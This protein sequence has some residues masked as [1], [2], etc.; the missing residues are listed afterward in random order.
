MKLIRRD[1][2]RLA[3]VNVGSLGLLGKPGRIY[4]LAQASQ[5]TGSRA[6]G[7]LFF[8][9]KQ[10]GLLEAVCNQIIPPDDYPGAKDAG[11]VNFIDRALGNWAPQHRWDYVAGLEAI[12]ESSQLM[13]G[14]SFVD[15]NWDQQTKV[16]EEIEKGSA[17]GK[18]W[19]TFHIGRGVAGVYRGDGDSEDSSQREFFALVVRHTMQGYY[20]DPQY[21]GNRNAASWKMLN[22]V[23]ARH[24]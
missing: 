20:S 3:L 24:H 23:L 2:F 14:R 22:Y 10:V 9:P 7:F 17:P 1:F 15:L 16:L 5:N 12:D 21:G 6:P 19:T 18:I 11:V 13:F 8:N 4:A